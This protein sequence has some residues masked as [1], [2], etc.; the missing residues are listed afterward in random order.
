MDK[1][2]IIWCLNA[3]FQKPYFG[4]K[5]TLDTDVKT[6]AD[7]EEMTYYEILS[8]M[9][10]L[11]FINHKDRPQR[12]LHETYFTHVADFMKRSE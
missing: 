12:W 1:D 11:M 6:V 9:I 7:L 8:R 4:R 2:E 10:E 3:D 5:L